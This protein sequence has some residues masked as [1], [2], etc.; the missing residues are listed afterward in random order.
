MSLYGIGVGGTGA[1]CLEAVTNLAAVGLFADLVP[2]TGEGINLLFVDADETN[3][4]LERAKNSLKLYQKTY[5]LFADDRTRTPLL[6]TGVSSLDLWS[7]FRDASADKQLAAFF[8]YNSLKQNSPTLGH[9]FDVL[10]TQ[11]EREAHLDVGFRGRPAIGSA[12]MSQVDFNRLEEEPWR[13]LIERIQRDAGS[14]GSIPSIVLYGSI[15]GGTGAAG[16]PTMGR[17]L[18]NKLTQINLRDK[19]RLAGVFL[20]PYF[21][22]TPNG[23]GE[24][25][26]ARSDQFML[27]TEAAL[28]YYL[29]QAQQMFDTV[30]LLGSQALSQVDFSIGKQSQRNKPHFLEVYAGLAARH[31]IAQKPEK[32][33]V[34]L[35]S[36][37]AKNLISWRDFPE[38]NR[39][40]D[41]LGTAA[42]FAYVWLSYIVPELTKAKAKVDLAGLSWYKRYYKLQQ[43]WVRVSSSASG[44]L[45]ALDEVAQQQAIDGISEW[46]RDYLRWLGDLHDCEGETI[47]LFD[48]PAL[49]NL[50]PGRDDLAVLIREAQ[51][52]PA[53]QNQDTIASLRVKLDTP[54][55][56]GKGT[57]GLARTLY[58][59]CHPV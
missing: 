1:K 17:L 11:E 33:S 12:V 6:Q 30:Y 21:S 15:F 48:A 20:L 10:Y 38:P 8:S 35:V 3:G 43:G 4:S 23:G 55:N 5:S 49:R 42:R 24:E 54:D 19:V 32:G 26:Y 14:G 13:T 45:P 22:F 52:N 46:C 51:P 28:R 2:T 40:K 29:T 50:N 44:E 16:L 57:I 56:L 47:H 58:Q 41:D 27:N 59:L 31:F 36:R 25:V 9:L 39:V 53:R 34:V 37:Q 18:A 7:P